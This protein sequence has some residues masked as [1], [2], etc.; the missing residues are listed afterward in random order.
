MYLKYL[1]SSLYYSAILRG[2]LGWIV[3]HRSPW[4]NSVW[5]QR[6]KID[7][8]KYSHMLQ[9]RLPWRLSQVVEHLHPTSVVWGRPRWTQ[10][11]TAGCRTHNRVSGTSPRTWRSG[12]AE[13]ETFWTWASRFTGHLIS[14]LGVKWQRRGRYGRQWARLSENNLA[15]ARPSRRT[16]FQR[17][18]ASL[19]CVCRKP[20]RYSFFLHCYLLIYWSAIFHLLICSIENQE[21]NF[22]FFLLIIV[23]LCYFFQ[24]TLLFF[25]VLMNLFLLSFYLL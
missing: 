7:G 16:L 9:D 24:W 19:F 10:W 18:V 25:Q 3:S 21:L 8:R 20:R 11:V 6:Y 22:W 5:L 4:S 12:G 17:M 2:L 1:L 15:W 14:Y 23:L 13:Q